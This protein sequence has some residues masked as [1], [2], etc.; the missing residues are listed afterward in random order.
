MTLYAISPV[1][2]M[3]PWPVAELVTS[4]STKTLTMESEWD[5]SPL[6]RMSQ[7]GPSKPAIR[8]LITFRLLLRPTLQVLYSDAVGDNSRTLLERFDIPDGVTIESCTAVCATNGFNITGLEF[9]QECCKF[10]FGH[11]WLLNAQPTLFIGCG[12]S[13]LVDGTKAPLSDCSHA[14]EANHTELCGASRRLSVYTAS[15]WIT[16]SCPLW[17]KMFDDFMI[18]VFDLTPWRIGSKILILM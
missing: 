13:F 1:A 7:G 3:L 10:L 5:R 6:T 12:S 17:H 18:W 9:G 8:K 4:V 15:T 11:S 2:A 14:C 16:G